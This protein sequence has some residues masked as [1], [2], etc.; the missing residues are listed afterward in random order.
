MVQIPLMLKVFFTHDSEAED[1]LYGTSPGSESRL[2][3]SNNLFSL[4]L[5]PVQY[6]I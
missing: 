2:F 5:E 1:L 4:A 3:F 6:N